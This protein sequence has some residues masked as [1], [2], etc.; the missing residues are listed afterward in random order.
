MLIKYKDEVINL[1]KVR[2]FMKYEGYRFG[3]FFEKCGI[4]FYFDGSDQVFEFKSEEERDEA[5]DYILERYEEE[6]RICNLE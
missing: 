3:E 4:K 5:F 2:K 1:D 6:A